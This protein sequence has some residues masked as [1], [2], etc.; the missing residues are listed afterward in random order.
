MLSPLETSTVLGSWVS[1]VYLQLPFPG[2]RSH[3]IL[4][5]HAATDA[6]VAGVVK[7][8]VAPD[9]SRPAP[10]VSHYDP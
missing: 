5:V 10:T 4:G 7:L 3:A 2:V 9:N 1:C 6:W 8:L